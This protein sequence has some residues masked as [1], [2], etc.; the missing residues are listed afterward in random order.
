[1]NK[2]TSRAAVWAELINVA[3]PDSR[4]HLD[5]NEYIPDFAGSDKATANLTALTEYQTATVAFI[6][7]DNCLEALRAQAIRD[8]KVVIMPTYGIRRGFV[9][10]RPGDAPDDLLDYAVLLDLIER[11]GR[12]ITL[13]DLQR[14]Y[15]IDLAVTGASAVSTSGVRFGKGHGFFDLEWAMLY[16]VGAA[17]TDTPAAAFGHDC[18]V[19]DAA[20][21][22]SPYDT[23]CDIV[24]TPTRVLRIPD[25]QKPTQGVLWHKLEPGMLDAIPPLRELQAMQAASPGDTRSPLK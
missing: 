14:R 24:V 13:A 19:I 10:L 25:A 2:D 7:P 22:A 12:P 20:L 3:L 5:F 18:Q 15:T 16:S 17:G 23:V 9:E 21:E 1:M 6:T 8:G 11:F 4:F